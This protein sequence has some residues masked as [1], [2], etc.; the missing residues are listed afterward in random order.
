MRW[1]TEAA[2]RGAAVVLVT[3]PTHLDPPPGV[4]VVRVRS[5]AE[6]H[7]AV[8]DRAAGA[9]AVIMAAAVADY[10]PEAVEPQKVAKKDGGWTLPLVRT[11]D[12]LAELGKLPSRADAGG[13]CSSALP[14]R[15]T[16]SWR[17]PTPSGGARAST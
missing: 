8:M 16:T 9:D 17:T 2:R 5:A 3:G 10:T 12:I 6:M 7:R 15:P 1:R 14:P 4:D 11:I 13:R